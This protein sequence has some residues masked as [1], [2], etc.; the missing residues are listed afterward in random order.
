M[1]VDHREVKVFSN[2]MFHNFFL[3]EELISK[4]DTAFMAI[5]FV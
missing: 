2:I 3:S 4:S 5:S 1:M